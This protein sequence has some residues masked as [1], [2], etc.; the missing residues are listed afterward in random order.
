MIELHPICWYIAVWF[1]RILKVLSFNTNKGLKGHH[2]GSHALKS[3]LSRAIIELTFV[4]YFQ[5]V[6]DISMYDRCILK[7]VKKMIW[8]IFYQKRVFISFFWRTTYTFNILKTI[9]EHTWTYWIKKIKS[10]ITLKNYLDTDL[11]K[12]ATPSS[13]RVVTSTPPEWRSWTKIQQ[14]LRLG[15]SS[16][17]T[18]RLLLEWITT[19]L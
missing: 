6:F 4:V 5:N 8:L 17:K 13:L 19:P 18:N 2:V 7:N 16:K 14:L 15:R 12:H 10:M 9:I 11:L 3:Y 1:F